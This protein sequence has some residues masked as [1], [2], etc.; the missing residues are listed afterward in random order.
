LED[1]QRTG[2]NN[3]ARL[4]QSD[5]LIDKERKK[6]RQRHRSRKNRDR[7]KAREDTRLLHTTD[8]LAALDMNDNAKHTRDASC[9]G[10]NNQVS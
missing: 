3:N 5:N 9:D 6:E 1:E 7:E 4:K 8:R 10:D 2:E